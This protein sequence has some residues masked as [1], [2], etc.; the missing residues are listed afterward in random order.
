MDVIENYNE[1]F[2]L[3]LGNENLTET[4]FEISDYHIDDF[5]ASLWRIHDK[6][7]VMMNK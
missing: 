1:I 2:G 7:K 4:Q 6:F 3:E 5:L